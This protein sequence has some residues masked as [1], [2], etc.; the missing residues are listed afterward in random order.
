MHVHTAEK[1][2]FFYI[3]EVFTSPEKGKRPNIHYSHTPHTH[4]HSTA[5]HRHRQL[6]PLPSL[7][8]IEK[9]W[10]IDTRYTK[11]ELNVS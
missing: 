7:L 6:R 5:S 1:Q 9:E 4:T 2:L 10:F 8:L 3:Y 11:Q